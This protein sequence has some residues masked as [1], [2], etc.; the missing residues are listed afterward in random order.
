MIT[1]TTTA[2]TA[3]TAMT[4]IAMK[5]SSVLGDTAKQN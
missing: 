1:P 2:T 5:L 4:S 3:I